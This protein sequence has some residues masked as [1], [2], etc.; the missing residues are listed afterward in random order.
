MAKIK[1]IEDLNEKQLKELFK[2]YFCGVSGR[3]AG[4]GYFNIIPNGV[5][6]C[7]STSSTPNKEHGDKLK[8]FMVNELAM[9]FVTFINEY[10]W[11]KV[12]NLFNLTNTQPLCYNV[13]NFFNVLS[14]IPLDD[15]L[16]YRDEYDQIVL[17]N[18]KRAK[19]TRQN[20]VGFTVTDFHILTELNKW[21]N[22]IHLVT[23]NEFRSKTP[24]VIIEGEI[25]KEIFNRVYLEKIDTDLFVRPNGSKVFTED[26]NLIRP[27]CVDGINSVSFLYF[28]KKLPKESYTYKRYYWVEND[29]C[30]RSMTTFENEMVRIVSI[31]PNLLAIPISRRTTISHNNLLNLLGD[32]SHGY[33]SESDE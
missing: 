1:N 7:N 9:H 11:N 22:Y 29:Y 3:A 25:E 10:F 23:S 16:M 19:V 18:K 28:L 5:I 17:T 30:I 31:Q 12:K 24:S 13:I 4:F 21:K 32:N 20:E 27:I 26:K 14:S 2:L 33:E 8:N 15:I 6:L